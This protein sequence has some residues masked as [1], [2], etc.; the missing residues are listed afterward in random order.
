MLLFLPGRIFFC[1]VQCV[2]YLKS[3]NTFLVHNANKDGGNT[4][5][6]KTKYYEVL[7][8][9]PASKRM[10]SGTNASR[11]K[12]LSAL[13]F[14]TSTS[15]SFLSWPWATIIASLPV[16][17]WIHDSFYSLCRVKGAS[18]EPTL[19]SGDVI[20]V[21]KSNWNPLFPPPKEDGIGKST[22]EGKDGGS[23]KNGERFK[24]YRRRELD[25]QRMEQW[26]RENCNVVIP[27]W[28]LQSPPVPVRGDIVVYKDPN[29]YN[30]SWNVKRV[31]GLGGQ[32]VRRTANLK[33]MERSVRACLP[34]KVFP[35][36]FQPMCSIFCLFFKN[37]RG[38]PL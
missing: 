16:A 15:T 34:C 12:I 26:E 20:L 30:T 1:R 6:T 24:R 9:V 19:K 4:P 8:V 10:T 27:P 37:T 14:S 21:R 13:S 29:Y 11:G 17:V 5:R 2:R 22:E 18:M 23:S 3:L 25:R 32:V 7:I 38:L 35:Q 31:I 36:R 33:R 28:A